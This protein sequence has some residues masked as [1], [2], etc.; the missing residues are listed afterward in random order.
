MWIW[1]I[2]IAVIIGAVIGYLNSGK[3]ED[4][5]CGVMTG[6]CMSAVCILQIAI[7]GISIMIIL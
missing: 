4:A 6:G 3:S 2:I 5:A 7:T 1:I